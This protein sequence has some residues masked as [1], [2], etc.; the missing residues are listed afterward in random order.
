MNPFEYDVCVI[1]GAGHVGLGPLQIAPRFLPYTTRERFRSSA[2]LFAAYLRLPLLWR[3]FGKQALV[4][5]EKPA[6]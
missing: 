3:F 5:A 4:V 6:P 2:F 1:G